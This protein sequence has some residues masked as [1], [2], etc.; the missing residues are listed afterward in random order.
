MLSNSL[1][2]LDSTVILRTD[3][4]V[5][6]LILPCALQYVEM[7]VSMVTRLVMMEILHLKMAAQEL[8]VKLKSDGKLNY[9]VFS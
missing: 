8:R 7:E 5:K 3:G 9:F 2:I 4:S 6:D 1:N